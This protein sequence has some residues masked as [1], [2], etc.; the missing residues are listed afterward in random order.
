M[1]NFRAVN[2]EIID[3][4]ML[5]R[6]DGFLEMDTEDL[7]I[8]KRNDSSNK[9]DVSSAYDL[10][11]RY[12][13]KERSP[14]QNGYDRIICCLGFKWDDSI[15]K[16]ALHIS[17]AKVSVKNYWQETVPRTIFIITSDKYP[18]INFDYQS[19]VYKG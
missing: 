10:P 8:K 19:M 7:I 5:K 16:S 3:A 12:F 4:Y 6:L 17:D 9:I 11:S 1:L 18:A 2:N 14:T 15:F 13:F